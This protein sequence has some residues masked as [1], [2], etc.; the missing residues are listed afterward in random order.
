MRFIVAVHSSDICH[1]GSKN[2][3]SMAAPIRSTP[4]AAARRPA[5]APSATARWAACTAAARPRLACGARLEQTI[6]SCQINLPNRISRIDKNSG[7][8]VLL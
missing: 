6:T 3:P 8:P 4:A 1:L 7:I 2:L 5:G